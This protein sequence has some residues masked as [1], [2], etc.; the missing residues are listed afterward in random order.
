MMG[1]SV[2][3]ERSASV[4]DMRMGDD[5]FDHEVAVLRAW[6]ATDD[7]LVMDFATRLDASPQATTALL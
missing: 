4:R 7:E 2:R 1:R 6:E 5:F 3:A